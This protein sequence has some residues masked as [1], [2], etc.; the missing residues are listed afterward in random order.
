[1]SAVKDSLRC[2]TVRKCTFTLTFRT[3]V[4]YLCTFTLTFR[5]DVFNF[6]FN[7]K[8]STVRGR[9]SSSYS[10]ADFDSDLFPHDW[11]VA[12]DKLGNGCKIDFLVYLCS[13]V[14]FSPVTYLMSETTPIPQPRDFTEVVS[15]SLV[16]CCC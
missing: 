3:D 12:Y 15:V 14:K 13:H 16:K 2:G 5:T 1:M 10:I 7:G 4:F 6:L 11:F 9:R 8:G